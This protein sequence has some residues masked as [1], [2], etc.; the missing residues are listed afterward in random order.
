MNSMALI[1]DF[2]SLIYPRSCEA[3]NNRLFAHEFFLCNHCKL[4]LPKS[5]YHK[6]NDSELSRTFY[7][8]VPMVTAASYYLYE[9]SGKTQRL[10]RAIKYEEQKEL[11]EHLGL[12]YGKEL[13]KDEGFKEVDLILPIPLHK[14]KLKLRGFNQSEWFAK[15]LAKSLDKTLDITSLERSVD[16]ATQTR[17]RKFQRWENVEGIFKL[18]ANAVLANK[19]V[20]LV[21]DVVTTGATIEA[22]WQT[23]KHVPGIK[24]SLASIAFAAKH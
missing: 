15:G 3:C 2:L 12:L 24:I 23:L 18:S 13:T 22:C 4:N 6:N 9:K 8:R 7:G 11:A 21:D 16:T 5:N 19:H 14:N 1:N 17:K 20:L 10:L